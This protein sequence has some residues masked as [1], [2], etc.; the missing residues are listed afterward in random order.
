M[1]TRTLTIGPRRAA[2]V[3]VDARFGAGGEPLSATDRDAFETLDSL[4]RALCAILYNYVPTSG[5]PG[6]SISSGRIVAGIL[7]DAMDYDFSRPDREDA[8]VLSYA[9]GHKA[10]GLYAMWALRDEIARL[11]APELLPDLRLRL[12][13]EDLLGFRRN[14]NAAAPIATRTR[15]KA[16][17]GHP[18]PATPF[19][20]LATGASGVGVASSIGLALAARDYYGADA[21]R[22]HVLEGEGGLT[23]G[24]V[25]EALAAARHR[26]ARQHRRARRLEPGLDRLR[27]RVP[28][29]RASGRLRAVEPRGALPPPRLERRG[30]GGRHGLRPGDRARSASPRVFRP[31]SR[32]RSSIAPSRAGATASRDAPLTAPDTSSA[33]RGSTKR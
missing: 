5:H 29:R 13:L 24:R 3:E 17:D 15:A 19:V 12:R 9:A 4:Y 2:F 8:D 1:S 14:P 33:P 23:P 6:G 25:A 21:P 18:T 22:V 7:F 26:F 32:P 28:R 20:R 16:L 30:R 10:M 27:P 11:G 31:A